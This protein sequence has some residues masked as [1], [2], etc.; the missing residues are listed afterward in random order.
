MPSNDSP[1]ES[2]FLAITSEPSVPCSKA[3][4]LAPPAKR[5]PLRPCGL[6][7]GQLPLRKSIGG[8]NLKPGLLIKARQCCDVLFIESPGRERN[9]LAHI[10]LDLIGENNVQLSV[11]KTK[12]SNVSE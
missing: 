2:G 1:F 12:T 5:K 11:C 6:V 9:L 3:P 8:Y 7:A 4:N 10:T